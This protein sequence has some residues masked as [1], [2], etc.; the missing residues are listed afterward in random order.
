MQK[1][2]K[3][4]WGGVGRKV[5]KREG[6]GEKISEQGN[7]FFLITSWKLEIYPW[8]VRRKLRECC[9]LILIMGC[10]KATVNSPEGRSFSGQLYL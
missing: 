5:R 7:S 1:R 2:K 10:E 8:E 3:K 9:E 6:L 4:V